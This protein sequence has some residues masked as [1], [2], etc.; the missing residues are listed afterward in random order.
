[1]N[2]IIIAII[3]SGFLSAL[4]SGAVTLISKQMD[5]KSAD[6]A[7]LLAIARDRIKYNC[8][9][10]I[11]KGEITM[12]ELEDLEALHSS[13]HDGGGNGYCDTLMTKVKALPIK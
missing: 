7:L 6:N 12:D 4:V 3:G 1:M 11:E 13:Y 8:R 5:K 9:I 2:E 10:F